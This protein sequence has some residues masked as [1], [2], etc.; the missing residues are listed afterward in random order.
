MLN[1]SK[2]KNI[3]FYVKTKISKHFSHIYQSTSQNII[4]VFYVMGACQPPRWY[5]VA[6]RTDYPG[7]LNLPT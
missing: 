3:N 7:R 1:K 4:D 6:P 5:E 2:H